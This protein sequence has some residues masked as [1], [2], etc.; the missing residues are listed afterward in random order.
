MPTALIEPRTPRL[1]LRQWHA[2]DRDA[3]AAMVAD[4]EVM[5]YFPAPLTRAQS[6]A[7]ADKCE[8]LIAERGWGIWAVERLADQQ[9]IGFVGLH[10]PQPDLPF[11]PCVE[12]AWRLAQH[13]WHQGFATEAAR[14]ALTIGFGPLQLAEIV[15]FTTQTNT[16]SQAVMQRLGM[17]RDS[18][19][20]FDHPALP[21]G[22][23]LR[24][25]VLYRLPAAHFGRPPERQ[26][27]PAPL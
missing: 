17:E 9:F 7:M 25:H 8:A 14:A 27:S 1:Q 11:S 20:D 18:A 15:A 12:I 6:D 4:P 23:P 13:A 22:H 10:V 3:F 16:P 2:R 24:P 26:T 5:R 21:A 19:G